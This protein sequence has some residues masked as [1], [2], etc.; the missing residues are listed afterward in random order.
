MNITPYMTSLDLIDRLLTSGSSE[1]KILMSVYRQKYLKISVDVEI[2]G[3]RDYLY[4][5]KYQ[6]KKY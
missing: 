4:T 5:R 6:H 2:V 3:K 1:V